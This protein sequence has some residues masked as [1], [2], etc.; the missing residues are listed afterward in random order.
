MPDHRQ[1]MPPPGTDALAGELLE[2]AG[3]LYRMAARLR[4]I[5]AGLPLPRERKLLRLLEDERPPQ[6][7]VIAGILG[8]VVVDQLRPAAEGLVQ[9]AAECRVR[10]R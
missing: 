10:A 4:E 2:S 3:A 6:A 5:E 7:A 1:S 8:S 9:A